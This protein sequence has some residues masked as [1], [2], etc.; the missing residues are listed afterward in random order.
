MGNEPEYRWDKV[1]KVTS[2]SAYQPAVPLRAVDVYLADDLPAGYGTG[3]LLVV[4]CVRQVV[5]VYGKKIY[6]R[7]ATDP[8]RENY[9][10]RDLLAAGYRY[11]GQDVVDDVLVWNDIDGPPGCVCS[12]LVDMNDCR[13]VVGPRDR[14][15]GWWAEQINRAVDLLKL[16][17]KPP[18]NKEPQ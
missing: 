1:T 17:A 5:E 8:G 4:G 2:V 6:S 15:D 7:M 3:D 12:V 11:D 16:D 14:P 18:A 10:H 13:I 9:S